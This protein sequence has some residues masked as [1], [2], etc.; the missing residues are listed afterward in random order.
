MLL[1]NRCVFTRRTILPNFITI[2]LETTELRLFLKSVDPTRTTTRTFDW[3]LVVCPLSST[4]G[5]LS[6]PLVCGTVF[7]RTS[8]LPSSSSAVVLNHI[9]SHCLRPLSGSSLI[10]TVHA[11]WLVI[12]V[13]IKV[14][15]DIALHGNSISELRDVTCHIMG[16]HSVTCHPT[17]VNAP[18][19]TPTMQAGTR[20][21]YPGAMEGWVDVVD[22]IAPRLGVE[23]ATLRS[24]VRRRTAA[25]P[26][27]YN[28][29]YNKNNKIHNDTRPVPGR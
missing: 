2:R 27:H 25:P 12:S 6:Q 21:T 14:K 8:L 19:L 20:F 16:S 11:Q 15:A 9:S 28:S 3:G 22:L 23:P 7:H 18:R 24:R 4:E 5:F 17:Q 26:R 10:C 13:T 29:Y 1:V